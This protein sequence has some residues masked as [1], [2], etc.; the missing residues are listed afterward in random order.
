[1]REDAGCFGMNSQWTRVRMVKRSALR[2]LRVCDLVIFD[3]LVFE[4]FIS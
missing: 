3:G 1:M 4:D 2:C